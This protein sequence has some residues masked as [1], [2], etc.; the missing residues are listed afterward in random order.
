MCG[1]AVAHA[2]DREGL[3]KAL[4]KGNGEAGRSRINPPEMWTGV[5]APRR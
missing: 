3:V 5:M 1:E 4:L 2:I